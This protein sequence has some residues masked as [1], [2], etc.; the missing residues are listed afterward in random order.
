MR[1]A[2]KAATD[3]A[4]QFRAAGDQT[5][6]D[7]TAGGYPPAAAQKHPLTPIVAGARGHP[8]AY[9]ILAGF[10][11]GGYTMDHGLDIE[12]IFMGESDALSD[13]KSRAITDRTVA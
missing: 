5:S 1:C 7:S 10:T 12:L 6:Q 2:N 8:R 13:S 3:A 9:S 4:A 11:A